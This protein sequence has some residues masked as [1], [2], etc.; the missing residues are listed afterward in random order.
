MSMR[1]SAP[2][3]GSLVIAVT[4][5]VCVHSQEAPPTWAYPI[6]PPNFQRT[7][8]DGAIRRVPGST[9]G[10]TLTQ[11]RDLFATPDWHPD[12]H[13]PMPEIVATGR[14]PD[15]TAC[16][17]CHR[18]DGSGG[19][20]NASLS[21][22][23]ADYIVQQTRKFASGQR[24]GATPRVPTALMVRAARAIT[25]AELAEAAAYFAAIKP[26]ANVTVR[27]TDTVPKTE[28]REVFLNPAAG[29]EQEPIGQRIIELPDSLDD[30]V[31]RDSHVRFTAHVP[32]GSIA[33]GRILATSVVAQA[34][35]AT[36]HGDNLRG[37][38]TAPR[39]AGR[40]PTYLFRQL[41]D[42]KFGTRHGGDS[43]LMKPVVENLAV[44]DMI[45][46]AAYAGSLAP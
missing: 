37:S 22:L 17:V 46:L 45:A 18:A 43:D 40:S 35:C 26:R 36:C 8:D 23:S 15:V 38:V 1:R 10:Y 25:D 12:E 16:G 2:L 5:G 31:S 24:T 44:D 14:R 11:V 27:E 13:A 19:A 41:F 4:T 33:R 28:V 29:T 34:T 30:F 21:G 20:E 6:N 42:I 39:L 7:P 3:L 9:A 32:A